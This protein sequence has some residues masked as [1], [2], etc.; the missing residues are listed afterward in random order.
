MNTPPRVLA[1]VGDRSGCSLWRVWQPFA[2]LQRRGFFAHWKARDDPENA[3]PRFVGN[4]AFNFDAVLLPRLFWRSRQDALRFTSGIHKAG[5]AII[6]E[7]DDDVY[8]PAIVERAYNTQDDERIKGIALL[9]EERLARIEVLQ[10]CDGVTVSSRR[11]QTIVSQFTEVPIE[12]VPNAIDTRWFHQVLHGCRRAIPPLT[13]G[14]A[15]GARYAEDHAPVAEAWAHVANRYPDVT[16]VV[17]GFMAEVLIDAVPEGRVRKLPWLPLEEYP[18]ALLNFDIGCAAVAPKL[19]NTAK[20]PIKVWEYAMAGVPAV[21]SPT[22]YGPVITD[23]EDGLLAET[24]SEWESQLS[25]LIE[26]ASLRR[27]LWRNQRRRLAAD[28]SLEHNWHRW[29]IAWDKILDHFHSRLL[30][31]LLLTA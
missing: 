23:G 2:E 16:F 3:D 20:T 26:D 7:T 15:G 8:S 10:L 5:M 22:L 31:R 18:R 19:F 14:W 29:P 28:H 27:R 21:A 1:L 12:V 30:N 17:Q 13:I 24:A 11:L 25:R 4:L 6:V 9:E